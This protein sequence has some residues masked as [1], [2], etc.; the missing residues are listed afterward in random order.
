[1][2]ICN[3]VPKIENLRFNQKLQKIPSEA[4]IDD[5]NLH[6]TVAF[7]G[8]MNMCYSCLWWW[9]VSNNASE[10][11]LHKLVFPQFDCKKCQWIVGIMSLKKQYCRMQSTAAT[12]TTT[13][14]KFGTKVTAQNWV[15]HTLF[16][17][18]IDQLLEM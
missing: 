3:V 9:D 14:T 17:R 13:T 7:G 11:V 12:V 6:E 16:V 8:W 5:W 4:I 2:L 18:V 10:V 1:M 15:L